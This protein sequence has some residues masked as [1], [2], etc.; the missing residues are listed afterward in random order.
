[1][2]DEKNKDKK[3]S[4]EIESK[5]EDIKKQNDL[6]DI[7]NNEESNTSEDNELKEEQTPASSEHKDTS[8]ELK[9]EDIVPNENSEF[10]NEEIKHANEYVNENN[11]PEEKPKKKSFSSNIVA[12]GVILISLF[13]FAF[14]YTYTIT[15]DNTA[16]NTLVIQKEIAN[17][18][19]LL[20][21]YAATGDEKFVTLAYG[22]LKETEELLR[23][24]LLEQSSIDFFIHPRSNYE[25]L[26]FLD[27]KVAYLE[28]TLQ[29]EEF[30]APEEVNELYIILSLIDEQVA[31]TGN[32]NKFVRQTDF[33]I[34]G[35]CHYHH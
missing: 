29:G 21:M 23:Q 28:N 24:T 33:L 35:K 3:D 19:H 1:M 7:Q 4:K 32:I 12:F 31:P 13:A 10:H 30:L 11:A 16:R 9:N 25:L 34:G 15:Q 18:T 6:V 22:N 26:N 14:I 5:L 8:S 27:K 20:D 2:S 17:T